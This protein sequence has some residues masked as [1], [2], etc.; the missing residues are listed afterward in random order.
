MRIMVESWPEIGGRP[1]ML[2]A[3]GDVL[4]EA[5]YAAPNPADTR[6]ICHI[7]TAADVAFFRGLKESG[8]DVTAE[9]TPHHLFLTQE[10]AERAELGALAKVSPPL[11]TQQDVDALWEALADGT[12]DMIATDHA[13][14]TLDEKRGGESALRS[15]RP[16]NG[17]TL[18]ARR[19]WP[20]G[21]SPLSG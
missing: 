15:A 14:H 19:R 16:R 3:T 7:S 13:P 12:I 2:H 18:D 5:I 1:V 20:T 11:G 21:A 4:R 9:V 8:N 17:A 10:M 6:H